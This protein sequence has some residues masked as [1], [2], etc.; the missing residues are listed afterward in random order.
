MRLYNSLTRTKQTFE[1]QDGEVRIYVC[2]VTVYDRPHVGHA[3]STIVFEV[4][5]RYLEFRG[6]SVKRIQN[7]TDVDDKIIDR[8]KREDVDPTEL[9]ERYI[10]R[11][12]DDL[13]GLNIKRAD[14]Y[15]RATAHIPEI[16]GMISEL[17]DKDAAYESR[18][19]VYF[20]VKSDADYG[21]LSRQSVQ[22]ML[23]GTR[24]EAEPGKREP[25]DFALWKA[26]KPDEPSWDSPWGPGRPGW[27]IECS[28]MARRHLGYSIDVHGGGL[29]LIFPHH[30]NELAQSET[31]NGVE[32]YV[33]VWMHNGL[34]RLSGEKMSKSI[35]NIIFAAE[36]LERFS[37]DTI[38]LWMLS[39]HYRAPLLYDEEAIRQKEPAIRRLRAALDAESA[40][41][42]GSLDPAQFRKRFTDVLD[43]DLNTPQAVAVL[44]DLGREIFR[45]RDSGMDVGEAQS[46]L[47]EMSNV[48][49]LTLEAAPAG[50][51]ALP[52]AEIGQ[53]VQERSALRKARRYEDADAVRKRLEEAGIALADGPQGTTWTR[54]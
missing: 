30:E 9:A 45:A 38:R 22:E 54:T 18:G 35:G 3:L 42:A 2:G 7:F 26:S 13:D 5:H 24:M 1:P 40:G 20:S 23:E 36:A 8:A 51:G 17:I 41:G 49:G 46:A 19:S 21:K 4:L 31:A 47:E 12:F 27:H 50:D 39:S 11:F 44:F 32:P 6:Y 10:D 28:A 34:L 48:L 33:G 52:D 43:D 29:D 25:A 14:L 37:A 15:P 53:L 16:V